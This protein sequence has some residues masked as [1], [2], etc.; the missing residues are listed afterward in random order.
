M[1]VKYPLRT[2][3]TY[4]VLLKCY[5]NIITNKNVVVNGINNTINQA[6]INSITCN[7]PIPALGGKDSLSIEEI[8]NM[9]SYNYGAQNRAVTLEDYYAILFKMP[10]RYGVPFKFITSLRNNNSTFLLINNEIHNS[11]Y[12]FG[13]KLF[14]AVSGSISIQVR[15]ILKFF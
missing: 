9:I 10:G 4:Y 11:T 6:V 7:N 1:Q 14:G 2:K 3:C 13:F 15:I 5:V 12:L 8:R